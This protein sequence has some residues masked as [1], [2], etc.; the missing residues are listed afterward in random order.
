MRD[1]TRRELLAVSGAGAVALAWGGSAMAA[2]TPSLNALAKAKG[3]RFGSCSAWS[4]AGADRGSFANPAYAALLRTDC[5]ILVA[6]NEFKWQALRPAADRFDTSRFDAMLAF[7]KAEGMAMRGH[8]LL[9]HKT[10]Y[11][12]RWL[13]EMDFGAQPRAAAEA[14]L[15]GHIQTLGKRYAGDIVSFDV[16]N[17]AVDEK[18]GALRESGLSKAIGSTEAMIDLAFHTARA[19]A[20]GAQLV[21]N[22]YMSWE[23]NGEAH[24][25]GVLRLLEGMRKRGVP[26]D[27][28][29][30]QSHIAVTEAGQV[31][32]LVKKQERPWRDFL[33]AVTGMGYKLV[34]TEFDV[35]DKALPTDPAVRDAQVADYA[36]AYLERMFAY[37][38][39]RDVLV[40]GMSDKYSWLTGFARR[41]DGGLQRGTPYD[42]QFQ[43]KPLR[44]A[45][46]DC[47]RQARKRSV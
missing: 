47:F 1:F 43:P 26:V 36:R 35:N 10:Q 3:M 22:D 20:P 13:N 42:A 32:A 45:I 29:G 28:L 38:Q 12:P 25:A 33:D 21:Y 27:A 11:Y 7:A 17:E 5:G 9:W 46:A 41:A 4:P 24:R 15:T 23:P 30:V 44:T 31:A 8:T 2:D 16:V 18:T 40:W 19:A 39:L 37:P 34:I 14:V 6:E